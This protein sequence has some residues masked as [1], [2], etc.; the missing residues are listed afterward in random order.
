MDYP[1]PLDYEPEID[2]PVIHDELG[3]WLPDEI[4]DFHSHVYRDQDVPSRKGESRNPSMPHV[5]DYYPLENYL[6]AMEHLFPGKTLHALLFN[7]IDPAGDLRDQ[8]EYL[9]RVTADQP[10]LHALM[11]CGLSEDEE[12]LEAELRAGH[13][14]GF[15]PY[16][17]YVTHEHGV[18]QADVTLEDMIPPGQRRLADRLG[19]MQ[20]VHIPRLGRLAD[21]VNVD[22]MIRLCE[23]CPNSTII[24]AHF[25]RAYFPEAVGDLKALPQCDN[26]YIDFSM[27]Q[28]WEACEILIDRFGPDKILFGLDMPVAQEKGKLLSANGQRHFFTKRVHPWSIHNSAGTYKMRCTFY[29]YE[30]VRAF[31]VAAERLGLSR[32]DVRNVFCD[33]GLRLVGETKSALGYE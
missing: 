18:P 13:F 8:N 30:I 23:Q 24:M 5:C 21:P 28:S 17:S 10:N 11:L 25:G 29:A 2:D 3:P 9:A 19:L 27:V 31:K 12:A 7:T 16:W 14:L 22:G 32:Q 4:F 15:K 20:L 26:L 33:N 1:F 6:H